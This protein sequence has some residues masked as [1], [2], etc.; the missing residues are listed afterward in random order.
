MIKLEHISKKKLKGNTIL[1]L[2]DSLPGA[3][4][5]GRFALKYLFDDQT[6]LILL[7]TFNVQGFGLSKMRNLSQRLWEISMHDLTVLKNKLIEEFGIPSGKIKKLVI[8]GHLATVVRQNFNSNDSLSFIIG[9]D[10]D[11]LLIKDT[12]KQA[13]SLIKKTNIRSLFLIDENITLIDRSKIIVVSDNPDSIA[14]STK[15]FLA[16]ISDKNSIDIEYVTG[17]DKNTPPIPFGTSLY[18]LKDLGADSQLN[19]FMVSINEK[20]LGF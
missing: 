5:A 2:V 1:L 14:E 15:E 6:R 20:M 4:K 13:I 10:S 7:Q 17:S 16:S 8:E 11:Q 9:A 18:Y 12:N 3:L 19:N